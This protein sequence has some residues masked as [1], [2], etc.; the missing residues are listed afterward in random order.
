MSRPAALR[1]PARCGLFFWAALVL[2]AV[3]AGC[4]VLTDRSAGFASIQTGHEGSSKEEV[5]KKLGAP[6]VLWSEEILGVS[7]EKLQFDHGRTRYVVFFINGKAVRKS[8]GK[9]RQ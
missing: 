3:N 4:D 2:A 1:T 5:V 8:A 7:A 6:T 9:E